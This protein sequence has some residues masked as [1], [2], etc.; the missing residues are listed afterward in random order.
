MPSLSIFNPSHYWRKGHVTLPWE[1]I[2]NKIGIGPEEVTLRDQSGALLPLQVDRVDPGD[3]SRDCLA[4]SLVR[5]VMPGPDDY[6]RASG[7]MRFERAASRPLHHVDT[8]VEC[9]RTNEDATALLGWSIA[10][11]PFG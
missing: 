9:E 10:A 6:T 2:Q 5:E 1:P 7:S 8:H 11:W 4:F 3:P